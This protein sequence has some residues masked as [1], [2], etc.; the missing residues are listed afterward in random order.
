L[1]AGGGQ[2]GADLTVSIRCLSSCWVVCAIESFSLI[3]ENFPS[4]QLKVF[5]SKEMESK[6]SFID[7]EIIPVV[8]DPES[9]FNLST[10]SS[11]EISAKSSDEFVTQEASTKTNF[12][13]RGI[14][15][16]ALFYTSLALFILAL[17]GLYLDLSWAK[18]HG[19]FTTVE[20][21]PEKTSFDILLG[22]DVYSTSKFSSIQV[23]D[24]INLFYLL[25][26]LIFFRSL[27]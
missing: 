8:S 21:T 22:F 10:T 16:G 4:C 9:I 26:L 1:K 12:M 17:A 15:L 2:G 25:F 24:F 13:A 18:Y 27:P 5:S 23:S 3:F 20:I 7:P 14:A 6:S 19:V 11:L